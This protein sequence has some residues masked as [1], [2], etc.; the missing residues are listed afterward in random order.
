MGIICVQRTMLEYGVR[1]VWRDHV[2]QRSC[3]PVASEEKIGESRG[4]SLRP[5]CEAW[6]KK[7]YSYQEDRNNSC[8]RLG[9]SSKMGTVLV[10]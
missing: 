2:A 1:P 5:S 3:H 4:A 6:R 9:Q 10:N 7:Y 8:S